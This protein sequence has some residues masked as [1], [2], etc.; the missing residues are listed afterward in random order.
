MPITAHNGAPPAC[1]DGRARVPVSNC[2]QRPAA[3]RPASEQSSLA[4][5]DRVG[6][7]RG[8][9]RSM[10]SRSVSMPQ[11]QDGVAHRSLD[12]HRRLRPAATRIF[13]M[14]IGRPSTS[15]T[16]NRAAAA[17]TRR[18]CGAPVAPPASF[19]FRRTAV[20]PKMVLMSSR[21]RPRTSSRFCSNGGQRPSTKSD[22]GARSRPRHRPPGR[23]RARSV[24][25]PVRSCRAGF[26]HDQHAHAEN[27][28][29]TR[30]WSRAAP[31]CATGRGA[32]G[33]SRPPRI[34]AW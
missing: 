18:R 6:L 20:S 33:R 31:R 12:Q 7:H 3:R 11:A 21:P 32:G 13:T 34:P 22:P 2:K 8:R 29:N 9:W 1:V 28:E 17:R 14:W 26:A 30:A 23:G 10:K 19:I 25:G 5:R 4:P 15:G 27:V 16:A 24:P